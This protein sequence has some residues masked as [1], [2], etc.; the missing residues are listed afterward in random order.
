MLRFNTQPMKQS[1]RASFVTVLFVAAV[2]LVVALLAFSRESIATIGGRFMTAL[3]AGDVD[4][5]TKMSY[6]GNESQADM[7]RQWEFSVNTAGKYYLFSYR[8]VASRQM[9]ASN[10]S[11]TMQ[12]LRESNKEGSYEEKFELPL[13]KVDNDWKVDVKGVS[14]ELYPALPR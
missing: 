12:V 6:L 3:E 1:G 2:L 7:R 9:D 4:T 10:A 11:V 13:V 5:L 14:R 8:I